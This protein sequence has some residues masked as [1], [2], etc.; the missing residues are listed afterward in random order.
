MDWIELAQDRDRWRAL[1]N[2]VMNLRVPQ[3]VGNF[4]TSRKPVGFSRMSVRSSNFCLICE[5][6]TKE[7]SSLTCRV[8]G[9]GV[10]GK[11]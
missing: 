3:I 6:P 4:L 9:G 2:S 7:T 1:V 8:G 10:G 5:V 11:Y